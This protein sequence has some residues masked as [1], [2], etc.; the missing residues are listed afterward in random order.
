MVSTADSP[1]AGLSGRLLGRAAGVQCQWLWGVA[2]SRGEKQLQGR[3]ELGRSPLERSG[4][5]PGT[6]K[7]M[8]LSDWHLA[9]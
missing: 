1:P 9:R 6:H 7:W 8:P 3:G 4:E 5:G 2:V